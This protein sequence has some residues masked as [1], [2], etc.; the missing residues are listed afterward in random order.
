MGD[1]HP[2]SSLL[3][4]VGPCVASSPHPPKH[5]PPLQWWLSRGLKT[6]NRPSIHEMLP[7]T[8]ASR[9]T[10]RHVSGRRTSMIGSWCPTPPNPVGSVPRTRSL[11]SLPFRPHPPTWPRYRSPPLTL[12]GTPCQAMDGR[13]LIDRYG[14]HH[15][16]TARDTC[17]PT[18]QP[19]TLASHGERLGT[20]GM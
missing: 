4:H 18:K 12:A 20:H 16:R 5:P 9:L 6:R 8:H 11:H 1:P 7:R 17:A 13:G 15:T 19:M 3:D 2:V 10:R 14:P